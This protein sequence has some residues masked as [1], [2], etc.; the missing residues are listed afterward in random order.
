MPAWESF[1]C[2]ACHTALEQRSADE[3]F[4]PAEGQ[5]YPRRAG[6]WRFLSPERAEYYRQFAREYETIRRA[7]GRG[8]TDA[9][10]Y[11]ALP[12]KDLSEKMPADW[13]IRARSFDTLLKRV[14]APLEKSTPRLSV[15]DL[16]A[17]NGWLSS[18]LARR[19]HRVAAVDLLDN[20]F[21]GLGCFGYYDSEFS[22]VQAEFD[23]LPFPDG[24]ADLVIFNA[25]LHYSTNIP[26]SL[27]QAL[28]VLADNG[29]LVILDSPVYHAAG[30]GEKMVRER[31]DHFRQRFGFPSNALPSENYLTYDFLKALQAPL[32]LKWKFLT[33][34]Y[35]LEWMLRPL[36]ATLRSTREPAKFHVIIGKKTG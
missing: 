20:T 17:G 2:P 32:A 35:G 24:S 22:P 30:S 10:Y 12:Y 33:P 27:A 23:R 16:G 26:A 11:R 25:S 3:L 34:F 28:H 13:Q 15:L 5:T 14:L 4:C 19:G 29:R 21:D 1:A 9:V 8:S 6:I 36:K 18:R 31:E 7:E